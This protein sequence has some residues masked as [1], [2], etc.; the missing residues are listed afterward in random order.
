MTTVGPCRS[1]RSPPAVDRGDLRQALGLARLEE[2]H[3]ARQAVRDVRAGDAAGVERPHGQLRAG[4]ADRLRGDDAPPR[5]RSGP[6]G[7][8]P[9][10]GRSSPGTR[11]RAWHLSTERTGDPSSPPLDDRPGGRGR[12]P[13]SARAVSCPRLVLSSRRYA[14][15]EVVVRIA[16]LV[17]RRLDGLVGPAV[18]M[19][20]I[21]SSPRRPGGGRGARVR[22]PERGVREALLRAPSTVKYSST[23]R[24]SMKFAF[25]GRGMI[26]PFGLV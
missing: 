8:R 3:D 20:T 19:R 26:S 18:L 17:E 16:P 1:P 12:S 10:S 4:L 5:R 21:T 23:S 25:T 13:G 24:P 22:G 11:R 15:D 6:A 14:A 7:P 2:L 9:A